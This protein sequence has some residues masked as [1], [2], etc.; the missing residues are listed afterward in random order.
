MKCCSSRLFSVLLKE[1]KSKAK[2]SCSV[3]VLDQGAVRVE[4]PS[5]WIVKQYPDSVQIHN[6]EPPN[7]D[8]VLGIS[9]FHAPE[10]S[11]GVPLRELIMAASAGDTRQILD[12]Q[13]IMEIDREDLQIAWRELRYFE[14]EQKREAFSR[15]AIAHGSEVYCLLTFDFWADQATRFTPVWDDALRSLTL[16]SY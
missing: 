1:V 12:T 11:I 6:V 16:G 14:P 9:R 15:M 13:K 10:E 4:F 3:C 7:D 8:C 2:A 5:D